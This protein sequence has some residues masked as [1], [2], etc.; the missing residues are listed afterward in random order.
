MTI[1]KTTQLSVDLSGQYVMKNNPGYSSDQIFSY[2]THSPTHVIPMYYSDGTASIYSNLGYGHDKQPYSMLNHSGYTK[3]WDT[4]LQSKVCL[5]QKMDFLLP[6][7][8]VKGMCGL[9]GILSE[10]ACRILLLRISHVHQQS[11]S[12][13]VMVLLYTME[14]CLILL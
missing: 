2:I 12:I 1:T 4:Y 5:E 9:D 6:G 8:S 3:T 11:L 14:Y 7:L 10:L 13:R